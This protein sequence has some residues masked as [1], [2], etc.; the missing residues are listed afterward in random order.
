MS[1]LERYNKLKE[2]LN[3]EYNKTL[4][5]E[6][7]NASKLMYEYLGDPNTHIDFF[8]EEDCATLQQRLAAMRQVFN[9]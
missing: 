6:M 1:E 8:N 4:N 3:Q 7:V 9:V 5:S 2:E